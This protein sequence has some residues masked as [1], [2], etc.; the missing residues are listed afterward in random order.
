MS[1]LRFDGALARNP[2]IATWLAEQPSEL[3]SLAKPWLDRIRGVG[4]DIRELM[5]DGL[6]TACV[7]DAPFAYVG[8]FA[9]HVSVGFFHGAELPDPA[10][11]LEGAGKHMRHVKLKPGIPVDGPA[12][13]ALIA[14]A[15]RDISIRL[16]AD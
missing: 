8:I 16:T 14:H 9:R 7:G 1:L 6:A 2:A 10:K 12:L 5:H 13:E 3:R 4:P 15:Y 11:L